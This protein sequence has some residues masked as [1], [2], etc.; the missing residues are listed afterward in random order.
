MLFIVD[1]RLLPSGQ[2]H[3]IAQPDQF[4]GQD[5]ALITL[6][7]YYSAFDRTTAAAF[8]LELFGQ[9]FKL[10]VTKRQTTDQAHAAALAPLGLP[11]DPND[12][13]SDRLLG[14]GPATTFSY[15]LAAGGTK[16]PTIGGIDRTL[17]MTFIPCQ[18]S[19]PSDPDGFASRS[20]ILPTQG[21]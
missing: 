10:L 2:F 19:Y 1:C 20:S 13:I 16:S 11:A 8:F 14:L 3:L 5:L 17:V 12:A 21:S 15:R 9:L 18:E 7:L 4:V 6:N